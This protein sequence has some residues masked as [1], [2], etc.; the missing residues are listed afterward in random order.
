MGAT[1]SHFGCRG[2]REDRTLGSVRALPLLLLC[3]ARC[4]SS[5]ADPTVTLEPDTG[6]PGAAG[7]SSGAGGSPSPVDA[8]YDGVSMDATTEARTRTRPL[9]GA[10]RWDA[11]VGDLSSVGTQVEA[12]LSPSVYHDRV[13]FYGSEVAADRIEA[14]CTTQAIVDQEIAYASAAGIDYFA[15]VAYATGS[16]LDLGR[17]LYL[18]SAYRGDVGFAIIKE[19]YSWSAMATAELLSLFQMPEYVKVAGGKPLLYV[20]GSSG[21]SKA[22]IDEIRTAA[23]QAGLPTPYIALMRTD[24]NLATVTDL[25]LDALSMYATTWIGD[26]AAYATLAGTDVSQWEYGSSQGYHVV[27]HVTAGWDKRPRHDHP[28]SWEADPGPNAWVAMPTPAELAA[29]TQEALDWIGTHAMASDAR[30]A[31]VYAWNEFDEGGF[32]CP[33]LAKYDGAARLDAIGAMLA[34]YR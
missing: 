26:G 7:S 1:C 6:A 8:T 4:A 30:T 18:S 5:P 22:Q 20:L 25:G 27:P 9:V 15:F 3:L 19:S 2:D 29:H 31:I 34:A 21:V 32:V 13:P 33:T 17:K 16:G 14:R 10:I 11:W 28:V 23:V 12:S 24:S